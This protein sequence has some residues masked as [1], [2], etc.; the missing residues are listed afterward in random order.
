[1]FVSEGFKLEEGRVM[2]GSHVELCGIVSRLILIESKDG[3]ELLRFSFPIPWSC[4]ELYVLTVLGRGILLI[5]WSELSGLILVRSVNIWRSYVT[6]GIVLSESVVIVIISR[7]I[8]L[9]LSL[10]AIWG[11]CC[12]VVTT[13]SVV[14]TRFPA[15]FTNLTTRGIPPRCS[16]KR[17]FVVVVSCVWTFDWRWTFDLFVSYDIVLVFRNLQQ[18][19]CDLSELT[20]HSIFKQLEVSFGGWLGRGMIGV[21]GVF[22]YV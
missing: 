7:A 22:S 8:V 12:L 16:R 5:L 11:I 21:N 14:M 15:Q 9:I 18:S 3:R 1:M 13:A 17:C 10:I 2:P 6:W 19:I 20:I 4:H